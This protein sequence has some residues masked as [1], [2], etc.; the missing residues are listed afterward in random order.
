[1]AYLVAALAEA[2][3][4]HSI[5]SQASHRY[6]AASWTVKRANK[7]LQGLTQSID[8]EQQNLLVAGVYL[9]DLLALSNS[10]S[11]RVGLCRPCLL[12]NTTE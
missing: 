1:M 11:K 6:N 7:F 4:Q 5:A 10:R 3:E 2:A 12:R 8:Q 9:A